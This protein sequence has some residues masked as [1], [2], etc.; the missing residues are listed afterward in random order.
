MRRARIAVRL[1]PASFSGAG[2]PEWLAE[3]L[4]KVLRAVP[5]LAAAPTAE[6]DSG[7]GDTP[8]SGPLASYIKARGGDSSQVRRFLAAA[9]WLRLRGERTLTTAAVARALREH[10]Q[11]RLG[12]PSDCLNQN[13]ARGFCEKTG[14]RTFYLTPDGLK[15]LGHPS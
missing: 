14:A 15:T 1:G 6:N 4:D 12:N 7:A 10:H 2:D 13:V 9:D 11:K 3:Q 5:L 8:G